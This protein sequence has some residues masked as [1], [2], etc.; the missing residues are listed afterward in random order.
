[1]TLQTI[2]GLESIAVGGSSCSS[3]LQPEQKQQ[4]N[5]QLKQKTD[6][7]VVWFFR[8]YMFYHIKRDKFSDY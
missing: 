7:L 3:L 8:C 4:K 1:M 5:K 6:A 2:L